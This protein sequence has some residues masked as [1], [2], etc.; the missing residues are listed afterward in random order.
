MRVDRVVDDAKADGEPRLTKGKLHA[1]GGWHEPVSLLAA[2][3]VDRRLKRV[4]KLLPRAARHPERD[5]EYVHDL[6]VASR[7]AA[8]TIRLFDRWLPQGASREVVSRLNRI[9]RAAGPARD[10]DVIEGRLSRLAAAGGATPQ[11]AAAIDRVRSRRTKAQKSIKR[12]H[13]KARKQGWFDERALL[14]EHVRWRGDGP[15]PKLGDWAGSALLPPLQR[16]VDRSFDDLTDPRALHRMRIAEKRVRY[17]LEVIGGAPGSPLDDVMPMLADLQKRLG[18]IND[19]QAACS[20]MLRW[21]DRSRDE[22]L[23][24]VFAH[25]AAFE[26]W[27]GSYAHDKFLEWWTP[28]MRLDFHARLSALCDSMSGPGID[29]ERTS[30]LPYPL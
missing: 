24:E 30:A 22:D 3:G 14:S 2:R 17:S 25:L 7:R 29:S 8:A 1:G 13:R 6:R 18:E 5:V 11:L 9:R 15:E 20:L 21:R 26:R 27:L 4:A 16:F 23:R 10:L 19:H 28:A 12:S